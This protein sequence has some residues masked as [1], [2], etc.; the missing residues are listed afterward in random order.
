[1]STGKRGR[2]QS[3]PPLVG[4]GLEDPLL[5]CT[6]APYTEAQAHSR[7]TERRSASGKPITAYKCPYGD[8]WH[9]GRQAKGKRAK[10]RRRG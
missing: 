5:V 8:H 7:A 2:G 3:K 9:V 10:G 6:K 1:M 4:S